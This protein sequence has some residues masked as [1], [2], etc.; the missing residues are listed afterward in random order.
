[1]TKN[2][3]G[4]IEQKRQYI[5]KY[6]WAYKLVIEIVEILFDMGFTK[7]LRNEELFL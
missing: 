6:L 5:G 4:I 3:L 7:N 2:N 1:M